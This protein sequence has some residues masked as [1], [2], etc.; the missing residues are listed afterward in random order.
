MPNPILNNT[1]IG[2][3]PKPKVNKLV[4]ATK[5]PVVQPDKETLDYLKKNPGTTGM[6]VGAGLN[7]YDGERRVMVNPYS[8]LTPKGTEALIEN[9]RIRLFIDETKPKLEFEPTK[10]QIDFFKGTEY[11]K[12]ENR[13][14]LKETIIARILTGD[15]SA[16]DITPEQQKVANVIGDKWRSLNKPKSMVDMLNEAIKIKPSYKK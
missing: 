9:E 2:L 8:G 1:L 15:G 10:A 11:G 3:N 5:Y 16:G 4:G 13:E 12:P 7:G 6:A 14:R